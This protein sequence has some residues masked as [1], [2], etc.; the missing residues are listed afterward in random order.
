MGDWSTGKPS[1]AEQERDIQLT[2]Q[3]RHH[4]WKRLLAE[5]KLS[6]SSISV[7]WRQRRFR[8]ILLDAGWMIRELLHRPWPRVILASAAIWAVWQLW[9]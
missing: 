8:L 4:S 7:N 1:E 5:W 3:L 2:V 6:L 9:W